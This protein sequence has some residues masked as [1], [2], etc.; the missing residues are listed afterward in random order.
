MLTSIGDTLSTS[1]SKR[2]AIARYV[3]PGGWKGMTKRA[4][5]TD[6]HGGFWHNGLAKANL[7]GAND[8]KV[9]AG[10]DRES[11]GAGFTDSGDS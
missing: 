8:Q 9:L 6:Q 10:G 2:H 11:V 4:V 1:S 3:V 5:S 7:H